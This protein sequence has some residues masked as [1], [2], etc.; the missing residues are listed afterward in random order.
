MLQSRWVARGS[1]YA[2]QRGIAR[3]PLE[4]SSPAACNDLSRR[5]WPAA[6][7]EWILRLLRAN[8]TASRADWMGCGAHRKCRGGVLDSWRCARACGARSRVLQSERSPRGTRTTAEVAV[9]LALSANW[10]QR[11][12]G[13]VG[14]WGR[15]FGNPSSS[16]KGV[17][18]GETPVPVRCLCSVPW[19]RGESGLG[20]ARTPPF[21]ARCWR[22]VA[23]R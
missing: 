18:V 22:E 14:V 15:N 7:S 9:D 4:P 3:C 10:F 17:H 2:T 16:F 5:R 8:T 21:M 1:L 12:V 11:K 6:G 19:C 13:L 23:M 20:T